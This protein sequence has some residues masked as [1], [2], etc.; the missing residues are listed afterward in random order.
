MFGPSRSLTAIR[1]RAVGSISTCT[2]RTALS[3]CWS[4]HLSTCRL[5]HHD[6]DVRAIFGPR[7][8]LV[9][10]GTYDVY[11]FTPKE[12]R[13]YERKYGHAPGAGAGDQLHHVRCRG[14]ERDGGRTSGAVLLALRAPPVAVLRDCDGWLRASGSDRR[15]VEDPAPRPA[16]GPRLAESGAPGRADCRQVRRRVEAQGRGRDSARA[17][18]VYGDAR[19]RDRR[20][21]HYDVSPARG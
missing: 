5:T 18:P 20:R 8:P 11:G 7:H 10:N 9:R 2:R 3:R 15:V 17:S 13:A 19:R 1:A 16:P 4:R 6:G 14:H 12:R 21:R